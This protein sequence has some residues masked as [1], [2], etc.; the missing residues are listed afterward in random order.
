V[1]R[2]TRECSAII[3][4]LLGQYDSTDGT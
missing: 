1:Q 3:R 2:L 4:L